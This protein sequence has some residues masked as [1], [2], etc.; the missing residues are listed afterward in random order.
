MMLSIVIRKDSILKIATPFQLHCKYEDVISEWNIH[1]NPYKYTENDKL[2]QASELQK[3][4]IN[5]FDKLINFVEQ[6]QNKRIN[7]SVPS[8]NKNALQHLYGLNKIHDN[9][10]VRLN[11]YQSS[12]IEQLKN[13]NMK[14]FF[15]NTVP[16][17]SYSLL[18]NMIYIGV[19][20]VYIAD[21]LCYN[22]ENVSNRCKQDNVQIRLIL[23]HIPAT[24]SLSFSDVRAPIFTPRHFE[25]LDKYIDVAEFDCFYEQ[26]SDAYNWSMFKVLYNAWFEKHD[27]YNDLREINLD[28]EIPYPVRT[29]LPNFIERKLNCGRRCSYTDSCNKCEVV[30]K[31]SQKL[32][33]TDTYI[34]INNS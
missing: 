21:D 26:E 14:F 5:L 29:E 7:I 33:D 16:V 8:G 10:Y 9:I 25:A 15:D 20:D 11:I 6:N 22:L 18:D 28:L 31:I 17:T 27:W 13:N 32:Y 34:K 3:E 1:Y 30:K 2:N 4:S 19:S 23:N 24:N 12:Y